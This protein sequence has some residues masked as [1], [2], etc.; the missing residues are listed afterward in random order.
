MAECFTVTPQTQPSKGFCKF[1][2][3]SF[4]YSRPPR[5]PRFR[6]LLLPNVCLYAHKASSWLRSLCFPSR[7]ALPVFL[8][9]R[10][11]EL[12]LLLEGGKKKRPKP[13][14]FPEVMQV[15]W[16]VNQKAN[17]RSDLWTGWP[18]ALAFIWLQA[19]AALSCT[20]AWEQRSLC[21]IYWN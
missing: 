3:P 5:I 21:R 20:S 8:L 7:T 10:L 17:G 18:S 2:R 9:T 11:S 12:T 6:Q 19:S 14:P 15:N 4:K 1:D 16:G 13:F